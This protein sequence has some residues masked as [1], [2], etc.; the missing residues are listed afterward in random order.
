MPKPCYNDEDHFL[1]RLPTKLFAR[2]VWKEYACLVG[3]G[4][5]ITCSYDQIDSGKN[6]SGFAYVFR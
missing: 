3:L 1:A 2:S 6:G 5:Y 4:A